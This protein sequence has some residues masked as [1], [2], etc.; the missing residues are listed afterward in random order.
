MTT[1]PITSEGE[2]RDP[3]IAAISDALIDH[4]DAWVALI[5]GEVQFD[6]LAAAIIAATTI[7][8]L[9]AQEVGYC[10]PQCHAD[11]YAEIKAFIRAFGE[12][13]GDSDYPCSD[14]IIDEMER[15]AEEADQGRA[16]TDMAGTPSPDTE[17]Q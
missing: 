14:K 11:E 5:D 2:A 6:T 7:D 13:C 4:K 12:D 10:N 9:Q 3:R 17:A 1:T 15:R 16:G 8:N